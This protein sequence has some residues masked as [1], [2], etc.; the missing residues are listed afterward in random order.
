LSICIPGY[1]IVLLS[2]S[3]PRSFLIRSFAPVRVLDDLTGAVDRLLIRLG[4]CADLLVQLRFETGKTSVPRGL[5]RPSS[6]T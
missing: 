5:A 6:A 1:L 4:V 3:W 2:M